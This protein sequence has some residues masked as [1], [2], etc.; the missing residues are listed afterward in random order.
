ME[1]QYKELELEI[2]HFENVDVITTSD[3]DGTPEIDPN[4]GNN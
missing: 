4:G 2:I 1:K 3:P